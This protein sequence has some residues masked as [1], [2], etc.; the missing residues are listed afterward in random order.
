[1]LSVSGDKSRPV[2]LPVVPT[3][4][5]KEPPRRPNSSK[6]AMLG[7]RGACSVRHLSCTTSLV[8][9]RSQKHVAVTKAPVRLSARQSIDGR[10]RGQPL[11]VTQCS[12]VGSAYTASLD[13]EEYHRQLEMFTMEKAMFAHKDP[14]RTTAAAMRKHVAQC[15]KPTMAGVTCGEPMDIGK[16][17]SQGALGTPGICNHRECYHTTYSGQV[18]R[19]SR[20]GRAPNNPSLAFSVVRGTSMPW[21]SRPNSCKTDTALCRLTQRRTASMASSK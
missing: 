1:M 4:I 6:T 15:A 21:R 16:G 17:A 19:R 10:Y 5:S 9:V 2:A 8:G 20:R 7:D 18:G 12:Q 14:G 11:H 3:G 13:I